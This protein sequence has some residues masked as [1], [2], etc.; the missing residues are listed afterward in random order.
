MFDFDDLVSGFLLGLREKY[1][2][3][4]EATC[5]VNEQ[6]SK[7]F[8]LDEKIRNSMLKDSL[9][10]NGNFPLGYEPDMIMSCK[11]PF[12]QAFD[13]FTGKKKLDQYI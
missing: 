4:T 10:R 5:F 7:I 13:K 11:S 2:T 12:A 1:K 6:V 8:V 9:K 3:T